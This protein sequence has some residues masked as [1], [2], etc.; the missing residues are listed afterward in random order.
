MKRVCLALAML[1]L[2][3]AAIGQQIQYRD[4]A[5]EDRFR[6]LTSELRCVMCQNQS[7]ADSN[8]GIAHDLRVEILELMR[9]GKS[10]AQI[11]D[12]LVARYTDF[13]LYRPKLQPRTWLL[14]FGPGVLILVGALVIVS[15]VRSK[16][17]G[18]PSQAAP[19]DRQEW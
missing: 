5:E 7:L 17:H 14:W 19:D 10:D 18:A 1:L 2:S 11:K 16:A 6:A 3:F 15:I 13:V 4:R 9:E 8:A 12:Y